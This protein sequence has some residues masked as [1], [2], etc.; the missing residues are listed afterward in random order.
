MSNDG[1]LH[2]LLCK[3]CGVHRTISHPTYIRYRSKG[4]PEYCASCSHAARLGYVK[5]PIRV[6]RSGRVVNCYEVPCTACGTKRLV[7][8]SMLGKMSRDGVLGGGLC[9]VC[10]IEKLKHARKGIPGE[11]WKKRKANTPK[12]DHPIAAP[13]YHRCH[14]FKFD[15]ARWSEHC[16]KYDACLDYA[17]SRRWEGWKCSNGIPPIRL[18]IKDRAIL[19]TLLG[20]GIYEDYDPFADD[21]RD[22]TSSAR[23]GRHKIH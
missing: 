18:D 11:A 9:R 1:K 19:E 2:I 14:G 20:V 16:P 23:T 10:A 15:P 22:L 17:E 8:L 12:G 21:L 7:T 13:A 6:I 4:F 5:P 3:R